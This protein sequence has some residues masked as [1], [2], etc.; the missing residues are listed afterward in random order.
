MRCIVQLGSSTGACFC[1]LRPTQQDLLHGYVRSRHAKQPGQRCIRAKLN[2]CVSV[3]DFT[4]KRKAESSAQKKNQEL[5]RN[6][7]DTSLLAVLCR[8]ERGRDR[9]SDD[10]WHTVRCT[11]LLHKPRSQ[12]GEPRAR[13]CGRCVLGRLH[14]YDLPSGKRFGNPSM[15]YVVTC[16]LENDAI[17]ADCTPPCTYISFQYDL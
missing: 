4:G 15:L 17:S 11:A 9:V 10:G 6:V 8:P 2:S 7:L 1:K 5:R 3:P 16:L 13:C 12:Q 14:L